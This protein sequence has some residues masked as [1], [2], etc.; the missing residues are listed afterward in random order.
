MPTACLCVQMG[1]CPTLK[2]YVWLLIADIY[3]SKESVV[4]LHEELRGM[5]VSI[6]GSSVAP[7]ADG[8]GWQGAETQGQSPLQLVM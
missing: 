1:S 7:G 6:P 8:R 4:K 5:R 2:E 3:V